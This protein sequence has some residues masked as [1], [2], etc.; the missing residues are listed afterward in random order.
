VNDLAAAAAVAGA[1]KSHDKLTSVDVFHDDFQ[2]A[3]AGGV[4]AQVQDLAA[5]R[6]E[7]NACKM[8]LTDEKARLDGDLTTQKAAEQAIEKEVQKAGSHASDAQ[9]EQLKQA[10]QKTADLNRRIANVTLRI[11]LVDSTITAIDQYVTGLRVIPAGGTRSPLTMAALHERLHQAVGQPSRYT[12]VL[13][14]KGQG[15]EAQQLLSNRP[16]WFKD[17]FSTVLGV[18]VTYMLIETG[19]SKLVAAGTATG[20]AKAYG[21]LGDEPNFKAGV[22]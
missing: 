13:L 6:Q 11:G 17:Y 18:G 8:A 10:R 9:K 14:I 22:S 12:H 3:Y 4:H 1:I 20:T 19:E 7:L 16:L 2:L 21:K 5:K 15:G